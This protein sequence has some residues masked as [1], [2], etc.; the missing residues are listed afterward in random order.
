MDSSEELVA[1]L[2]ALCDREGGHKTVA[3]VA[4]ISEANLWQVLHGI[5]LPSGKKRG[6][7]R[8]LVGKLDAKFPGWT[9]LQ[10]SST[11]PALRG[12]PVA[13]PVSYPASSDPPL[14]AWEGLMSTFL[15]ALFRVSMRD[16]SMSP[17]LLEGDLVKFRTSGPPVRGQPVLLS[18]RHGQWFV[19][20][21]RPRTATAWSAVPVN[22]AYEA[23]DA[24][25]D[26]LRILAAFA[27]VDRP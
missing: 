16:D 17:W 18:D 12:T 21:Y 22:Q 2:A 26:D 9:K 15:P 5:K 1:A 8:R 14:I 6:I 3:M 27:G 19:R 23:L 11:G 4:G 13:H 24:E 7:G 10:T 25:R 20:L